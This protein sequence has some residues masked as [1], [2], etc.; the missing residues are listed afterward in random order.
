MTND[1]NLTQPNNQEIILEEIN[2]EELD[3]VVGGGLFDG[4]FGKVAGLVSDLGVS[5]QNFVG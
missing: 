5:L 2:E 4:L 1:K 3:G